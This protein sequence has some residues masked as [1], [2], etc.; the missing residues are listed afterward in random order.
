MM[1][2]NV[3]SGNPQTLMAKIFSNQTEERSILLYSPSIESVYIRGLKHAAYIKF[4]DQS[5]KLRR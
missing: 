1:K 4:V 3:E 5:G 2:R